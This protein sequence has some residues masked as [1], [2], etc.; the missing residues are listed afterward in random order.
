MLSRFLSPY[1]L[2]GHVQE[3]F[4][5]AWNV[6]TWF[7]VSIFVLQ[8]AVLSVPFISRWRPDKHS[9]SLTACNAT[10]LGCKATRL[11]SRASPPPAPLETGRRIP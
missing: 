4:A 10:Q 11:N 6:K 8:V 2:P 9:A 5:E 7:I 3:G 1:C